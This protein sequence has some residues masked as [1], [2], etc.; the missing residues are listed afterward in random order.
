MP[1]PFRVWLYPLPCGLAL[2]GWLYVYVRSGWL[3]VGLG[4]VTLLAGVAAFF[5]WSRRHN[6]W[7]FGER[8]GRAEP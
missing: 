3:F 5:L 2:A 1:R 7:P 4:M 8:T 6:C